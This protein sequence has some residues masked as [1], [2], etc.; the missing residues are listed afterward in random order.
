MVESMHMFHEPLNM[1][2]VVGQ[3]EPTVKDEEI[4]KDLQD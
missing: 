1:E 4:N 2:K 3:I